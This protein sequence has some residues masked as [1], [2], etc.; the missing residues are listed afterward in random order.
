MFYPIS[1]TFVIMKKKHAMK[2]L[3]TS[4]EPSNHNHEWRSERNKYFALQN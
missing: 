4:N 3:T 2:T 1:F